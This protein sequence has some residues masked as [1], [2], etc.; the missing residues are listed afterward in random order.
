MNAASTPSEPTEEPSSKGQ[1]EAV[2]GPRCAP[3]STASS[4]IAERHRQN[5]RPGK[6]LNMAEKGTDLGIRFVLFLSTAFGRGPAR[7]FVSFLAVWYFL[8]DRQ[9]RQASRK[10]LTRLLDAPPTAFDVF[11]HLRTFALVSLDR[12]FFAVGKTNQFQVAFHGEEHMGRLREE[13][14]GAI[15]LM[16][17]LGSF[18]CGRALAV[19]RDFAINIVGMFQN[20]AKITEALERAN[21]GVNTRLID[22]GNGDSVEFVF[23]IQQYVEKGELVAIM[24]DRVGPDGKCIESEFLGGTASF[25]TGPYLLSKALGCPVF[26]ACGLY[27][28]PNRYD[29]YCEPFAEC[30]QLPR[31][32][33]EAALQQYIQQ[34]A[35][36][37][38]KYAKQAPFNWFNFF[39]YWKEDGQ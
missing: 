10:A 34:Y 18:E 31:K 23:K 25:P 26:F 9:A 19:Q 5:R 22:I 30:I 3:I 27:T 1:D 7:L 2:E 6:W 8:V 20:A 37:L 33:K 29:L 13:K 32:S 16:A 21:P 11:R 14:R 35:T 24:A 39:S 38:K 12:L 4:N 28:A 36:L 17:H 15:M